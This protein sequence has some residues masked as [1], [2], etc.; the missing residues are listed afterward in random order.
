MKSSRTGEPLT[1]QQRKILEKINTVL[2]QAKEEDLID[3]IQY[4]DQI[5][6]EYSPVRLW[7]ENDDGG[8]IKKM[9]TAAAKKA[10]LLNLDRQ[11]DLLM[12][13]A[14]SSSN[15]DLH[16]NYLQ[17]VSPIYANAAWGYAYKGN[18]LELRKL[19]ES[20]KNIA[21]PRKKSKYCV[22]YL[23]Q[24]ALD[25]F[26]QTKNW[27]EISKLWPECAVIYFKLSN[28]HMKLFVR[29][30]IE[31]GDLASLW[32]FLKTQA[33]SLKEKNELVA[34]ALQYLREKN[35]DFESR[36]LEEICHLFADVRMAFPVPKESA[37]RR[38]YRLFSYIK[39]IENIP[40]RVALL[41]DCLYESTLLGGEFWF[42]LNTEPSL[43]HGPLNMVANYL[44][45]D[46]GLHLTTLPGF[47]RYKPASLVFFTLIP[48]YPSR[49]DLEGI[50]PSS[51]EILS[52]YDVLTEEERYDLKGEGDEDDD[53]AAR[54]GFISR[55]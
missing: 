35:W 12:T 32:K 17:L 43:N 51:L 55:A 16:W 11:A 18:T 29:A 39:E 7:A 23:Y 41:I 36:K 13:Q 9:M 54:R 42:K 6:D 52:H 3:L 5:P 26:S 25:A 8:A 34:E 15:E 2:M 19:Y 50:L 53:R 27:R 10:S 37:T 40:L 44:E 31:L 38:K 1:E 28:E 48:T 24:F 20:Y 22:G 46:V 45:N 33:P 49:K 4:L 47:E 21:P 14:Y 30:Y